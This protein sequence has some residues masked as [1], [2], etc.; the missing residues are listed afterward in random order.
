ML[1]SLFSP[2]TWV[3]ESHDLVHPLGNPDPA[4][5]GQGLRSDQN[6]GPGE[7]FLVVDLKGGLLVYRK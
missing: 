6:G 5:K 4:N 7:D 3:G 2:D 1:K